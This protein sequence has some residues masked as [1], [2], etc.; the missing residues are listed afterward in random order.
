MKTNKEKV[1]KV[2]GALIFAFIVLRLILNLPNFS[3]LLG[4]F[5]VASYLLLLAL[6]IKKSFLF[7]PVF[8][9]FLSID[10]MFGSYFFATGKIG[11]FEYFGTMAVNLVFIILS[12]WHDR[13]QIFE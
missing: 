6:F 12:I 11:D 5:F 8:A 2:A 10:S 9:V 13:F 3:E 7:L 1:E 4:M